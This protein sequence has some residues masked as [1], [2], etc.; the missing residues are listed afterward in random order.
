MSR[1]CLLAR[2]A[3]GCGSVFG[4]GALRC[5]L[6]AAIGVNTRRATRTHLPIRRRAGP[7]GLID[8][9]E[10]VPIRDSGLLHPLER[11]AHKIVA[12]P[13]ELQAAE[14]TRS[15]PNR[16][17]VDAADLPAV[18]WQQKVRILCRSRAV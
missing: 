18:G 1:S 14:E 9:F 5:H 8:G 3:G 15:S 10:P 6:H 17:F 13:Q 2:Q 16:Y 4:C 11:R 7:G 12:V